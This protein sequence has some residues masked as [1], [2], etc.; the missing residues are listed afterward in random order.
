[1]HSGIV[2]IGI[3]CLV[4]FGIQLLPVIS[5]PIT[6]EKLHYNISFSTNNN[7]TFG[8]LGV[9]N[10]VSH[11]CSGVSVGY[12][13]KD[14]ITDRVPEYSEDIDSIS[15]INLPSGATHLISKLLVV[16]ILAFFFTSVLTLESIIVALITYVDDKQ[17]KEKLR[18]ALAKVTSRVSDA[19]SPD[20]D[21]DPIDMELDAPKKRDITP[22][23]NWM[24]LMAGLSFLLTLLAFLADLILFIPRLT[25][26]GW[27]Q[28]L[29]VSLMT[30]NAS[31]LCFIKRSILSR[32][33]L[34][35]DY[36]G[37]N[38]DMRSRGVLPPWVD[39]SASD[40]GFYVYTNG[41]YGGDDD[42]LEDRY[43][44]R[45]RA[46]DSLP[47]VHSVQSEPHELIELRQM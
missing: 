22:H 41:F 42:D 35:E 8:V 46:S 1:M 10:L 15:S 44:R 30:L 24:L 2:F 17:P 37:N 45:Q 11:K 12:P 19:H 4:S 7:I 6:G 33:H 20:G 32:R 25:Y 28:L 14:S 36:R 40:D 9:C 43:S 3:L 5:V 34:E 31:L 38:N 16:H 39:D 47:S 27:I 21:S 13:F 23:L 29:P 26:L 18:N